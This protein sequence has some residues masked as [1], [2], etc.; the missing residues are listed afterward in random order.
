MTLLR[1]PVRAGAVAVLGLAMTAMTGS[2]AATAASAAPTATRPAFAALKN[3]VP[4][5]TDKVT[6]RYTSKRMTVE[7]ALA[8]RHAGGLQAEL[9]SAYTRGSSG[10]HHWLAAVARYLRG[11]GLTVGTA[12]SPFLIKVT[13]SS[14]KIT[15]A[16][17]TSLSTYR[18]KRGIRYFANS[19]AV[20]MPRRLTRGVLGVIGLTNTIRPRSMAAKATNVTRPAAKSAHAANCEAPYP[21]RKQLFAN[22][23]N[24]TSFPFGFG[25]APGCNG[26]TPSQTNS[27]YGAPHA[28]PRGKGRGVTIA[29]FEL[30]AYLHSD[31]AHY[32]HQFYGRHYHAPLEDVTIDGG[33]LHPVCP[34]GDTC[35]PGAEQY[36]GDIEVD[37]DIEA[38][39]AVAPDV[40]HLI[41]YNAPNDD[42]GQTELDE[43]TAIAKADK[44]ASV[45]SSWAECENDLS[46][47]Y[48]Q[49]E[50]VIFEQMAL[51]GQSVFGAA[52]DTGAFGC[53]RS[54]GTDIPNLI[55][56]PSQPWVTDV[57][58]TS[59][60]EAN[61]GHNPHPSYPR[62]QETVWNVDNLC[63][64]KPASPALDNQDGYFWCGATGAGGGG[65]SEYW[66][67]P[68]Y[69]HGPGVTNPQ[70]TY[71]NST[72][73]CTLAAAGT[74]CR[75]AP[76]VSVDADEYTP[77]AEYCTGSAATPNSVCATFSGNQT[78]PGWFGIGGTSLA[79]PVWSA[80]IADRDSYQGFRTGNANPLLY[81]LYNGHHRTRYF[82]DIRTS[83]RARG[84]GLYKTR[85]HYD[86]A[87]GIGTPKMAALITETF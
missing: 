12:S 50:N 34:A 53:I 28:G 32:V 83:W 84:N 59:L 24:G 70:T 73:Q 30:S 45:S 4:S 9:R 78:P 79:S 65:G 36:A 62:G 2:L 22:V 6:G 85:R 13:G 48:V 1:H 10:Y 81:H 82:H 58:G 14:Q 15:A 35:P 63:S 80:I 56:P 37:A 75:E 49:A 69:Q 86:E 76:D 39:L 40:R 57:G 46:A 38:Q 21:T 25:G 52:G 23:N 51:Q 31:I 77:Y 71:A 67:R 11:A 42:T 3:S 60:E 17:K 74:P 66:G 41:V 54:D 61:P 18:D 64:D 5:T 43:Y 33:P 72:T 87:T 29:V 47:G 19:T 55:D 68:F 16:F 20:R 26:L 8:P 7:V 44:A 27:I